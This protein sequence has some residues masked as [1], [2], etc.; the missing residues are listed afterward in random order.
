MARSG[1]HFGNSHGDKLHSAR[2]YCTKICSTHLEAGPEATSEARA[3]ALKRLEHFIFP[4]DC[5]DTPRLL[6]TVALAHQRRSSRIVRY[7]SNHEPDSNPIRT[8]SLRCR[9]GPAITLLALLKVH[10]SGRNSARLHLP[11]LHRPLNNKVR[12]TLFTQ[13]H[14]SRMAKRFRRNTVS[15]RPCTDHRHAERVANPVDQRFRIGQSYSCSSEDAWK[16]CIRCTQDLCGLR[17]SQS[18]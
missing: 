16:S 1:G 10:R 7:A 12:T 15:E 18:Y 3:L 11:A 2:L 6:P 17:I 4:F 9:N 8:D 5:V 13:G 14:P